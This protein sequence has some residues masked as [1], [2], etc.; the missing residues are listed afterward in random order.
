MGAPGAAVSLVTV[1]ERVV[2][3]LPARS[4]DLAVIVIVPSP[5]TAVLRPPTVIVPAPAVPAVVVVT[6]CEPSLS[7]TV[8]TSLVSELAASPT[9]TEMLPRFAPLM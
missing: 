8:T 2:E 9:E 6:D 3:T 4:V 5:S 7:V 1:A